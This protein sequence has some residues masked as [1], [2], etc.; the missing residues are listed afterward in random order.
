MLNKTIYRYTAAVS[1]LIRIMFAISCPGVLR[2]ANIIF[3]LIVNRLYPLT[4]FIH[5]DSNRRYVISVTCNKRYEACLHA[6]L[7]N[8]PKIK[9][10]FWAVYTI[11]ICRMIALKLKQSTFVYSVIAF[12]SLNRLQPIVCKMN[13]S[14]LTEIDLSVEFVLRSHISGF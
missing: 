1:E 7:V 4:N 5:T 14:T 9:K 11:S 13:T 12:Q 6:Y 2:I 8:A 3:R 10:C